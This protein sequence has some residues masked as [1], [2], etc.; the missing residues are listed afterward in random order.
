MRPEV[1]RDGEHLIGFSP[2]PADVGG[3]GGAAILASSG[4]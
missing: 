4:G 3:V 2:A 1:P